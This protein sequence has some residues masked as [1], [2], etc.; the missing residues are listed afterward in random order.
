MLTLNLADV[1]DNSYLTTMIF[2]IGILGFPYGFKLFCKTY[3]KAMK[4]RASFIILIAKLK[5]NLIKTISIIELRFVKE[6]QFIRTKIMINRYYRKQ[7]S[8]SIK[9]GELNT[10]NELKKS[11][12]YI[13]KLKR[14]K[15]MKFTDQLVEWLSKMLQTA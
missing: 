4:L 9:K 3:V 1:S 12:R 6:Y 7:I 8:I 2:I 10:A 5:Y 11:L 13:N 14:E 15:F